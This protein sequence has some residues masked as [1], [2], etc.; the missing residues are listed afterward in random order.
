MCANLKNMRKNAKNPLELVM[1]KVALKMHRE[2]QVD[3][4][5][6]AM[7]H[8]KKCFASPKRYIGLIID[9]IINE[10]PEI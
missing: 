8:K 1:I 2:E 4:I 7:D 3:E 9:G 5:K 10:E 6:K